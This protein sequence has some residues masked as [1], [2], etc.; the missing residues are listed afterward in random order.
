MS[1]LFYFNQMTL[2]IQHMILNT[3]T[4][5]QIDEILGKMEEMA[6]AKQFNIQNFYLSHSEENQ[7]FAEEFEQL[8]SKSD[9]E[10][11]LPAEYYELKKIKK[12]E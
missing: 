11:F 1:G 4:N 9:W 5:N 2:E 10:N 8:L 6:K 7:E 12:D 3:L